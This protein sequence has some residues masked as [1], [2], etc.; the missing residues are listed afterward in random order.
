M[1]RKTRSNKLEC[2]W[3]KHFVDRHTYAYTYIQFSKRNL[4][5]CK[6]YKTRRR[7]FFPTLY[8]SLTQ[9]S[10]TPTAPFN[11]WR[12]FDSFVESTWLTKQ[13]NRK[14]WLFIYFFF[15]FT[16]FLQKFL[17]ENQDECVGLKLWMLKPWNASILSKTVEDVTI[18]KNENIRLCSVKIFDKLNFATWTTRST[19]K[20]SSPLS[21]QNI[22]Y[23]WKSQRKNLLHFR[24]RCQWRRHYIIRETIKNYIFDSKLYT[25]RLVH[26]ICFFYF[27]IL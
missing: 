27:E 18:V 8:S 16:L 11:V 6:Q 24:K 3:L 4:K 21:T 25:H 12:S 15:V 5:I 26:W 20:K 10:A 1:K 23:S 22:L 19:R 14:V 7:F 9:T 2:F 17:H 13:L